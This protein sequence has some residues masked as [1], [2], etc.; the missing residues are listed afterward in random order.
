LIDLDVMEIIMNPGAFLNISLEGYADKW[1]PDIADVPAIDMIDLL[2]N[3]TSYGISS[4]WDQ[5]WLPVYLPM[6]FFSPIPDE[7]TLVNVTDGAETTDIN[8]ALKMTAL[9]EFI[10]TPVEKAISENTIPKEFVLSQNF[11][12]PFNPNTNFFYS[13]PKRGLVR[14]TV[15]DLLGRKVRTLLHKEVQAGA[16]AASWDGRDKDGAA[17][18]S[19][20]YIIRLE[21]QSHVQAIKVTL[22]R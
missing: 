8:F 14:L 11:P 4:E 9:E 3:F 10:S 5:G 22:I 1:Y 12:N 18:P 17:M 6:P 19:S 20:I 21:S 13:L 15:Y 2:I 16:H 7:A